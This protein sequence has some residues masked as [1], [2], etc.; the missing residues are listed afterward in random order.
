LVLIFLIAA[1]FALHVTWRRF[2]K[3]E[4]DAKGI[5]S[6][7]SLYFSFVLFITYLVLPSATTS[8]FGMFPCQDIDPQGRYT[9]RPP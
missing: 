5:H 7:V 3:K 2:Y 4:E 1:A 8:I 9:L 6:V